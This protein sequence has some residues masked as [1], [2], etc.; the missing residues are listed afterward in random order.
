MVGEIEGLFSLL[1]SV[2]ITQVP[3]DVSLELEK[4]LIQLPWSQALL[5]PASFSPAE[6]LPK[7]PHLLQSTCSK[8][9][10]VISVDQCKSSVC[11][12]L[13]L[14]QRQEKLTQ[15]FCG[16]TLF[17][18]HASAKIMVHHQFLLATSDAIK[19]FFSVLQ[20]A[21]EH[22][23]ELKRFHTNNGMFKSKAFVEA[24]KDNYQMIT[25]SDA[26]AHHQKGDRTGYWNSPGHGTSHAH[27]CTIALAQWI[28]SF[29]LALC[30]WLCSWNPQQPSNQSH[31]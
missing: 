7:L 30:S 18:D 12:Q 21:M 6:T 23:V 29:V 22:G 13:L 31:E 4:L 8:G 10:S 3:Q 1:L 16:G 9:G 11:S 17:Y 25:K 5:C 2:T 20:E 15:K 27:S 14:T 24:L 19:S 28:W 26:G